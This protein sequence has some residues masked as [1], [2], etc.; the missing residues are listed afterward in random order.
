MLRFTVV[1]DAAALTNPPTFVRRRAALSSQPLAGW[2]VGW[3]RT[4]S[5]M[6]SR[7]SRTLAVR[8][9]EFPS[10][11]SQ[12]WYARVERN[13]FVR[14]KQ[15]KRNKRKGQKKKKCTTDLYIKKRAVIV[16]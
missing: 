12:I 9:G 16:S 11:M 15:G 13:L 4:P 6:A 2:L 14:W 10:R 1:C 5:A 8:L 7:S 3:L